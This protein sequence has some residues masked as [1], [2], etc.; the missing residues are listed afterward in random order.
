MAQEEDEQTLEIG[1]IDR[2]NG[3]LFRAEIDTSAPFESVKEAVTKFGGL[4]FWK[5]LSK[6]SST[7]FLLSDDAEEVD[8]EKVEEQAAEL[9]KELRLKERDTLEVLKELEA[10]KLMVE[11]LKSKL[12]K[13]ETAIEQNIS[14]DLS[15]GKSSFAKQED[16][17]ENDP[18]L[19]FQTLTEISNS[20]TSSTT[21][22]IL[23]ELQQAKLNLNKTTSDL[24][25][26]RASVELYNRKIERERTSL[27]KTRERL[28]SNTAKITSLEEEISQTRSKLRDGNDVTVKLQQL[29]AEVDEY[30]KVGEAAKSEVVTV[31]S[32]IEL[33]KAKIKTTG[34]RLIAAQRM[35][36]AARAAEAVALA[37]IKALE[38][39]DNSSSGVLAKDVETVTLTLEEYSS[40][41]DKAREAEEFSN[42]KVLEAMLRVNEADMSKDDIIKKGEEAMEEVETSK[43]GLEDALNRV[44]AA[45]NAKLAVEEALR[46]WRSENGERRRSYHNST[47]FKNPYPSTRRR[48]SWMVDVNG[49]NLLGEATTTPVL[50]PNLSI[51]QILS[52][53]LLITEE[54]ESRKSSSKR[55]VSLGQM[56]G[57]KNGEMSS[58]WKMEECRNLTKLPAKRKKFGFARFSVLLPKHSRKTKK[59]SSNARYSNGKPVELLS[60]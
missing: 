44:K 24:T 50:K 7:S 48:D 9:E 40:L 57:K 37:E 11:E 4:G 31:M 56:L 49:V 29:N 8:V 52:R 39:S 35:T 34:I 22:V 43:K 6:T 2:E 45:N 14:A 30:K 26:V 17:K 19:S 3:G 5:P 20:V 15:D 59:S 25:D 41:R 33:T 1:E 32:E 28:R 58:A 47:K 51:G 42:L 10:T 13:E 53:K 16:E 55:K 46:K 18:N 38:K 12:R 54:F 60:P 36:E 27:E 21:G 23:V